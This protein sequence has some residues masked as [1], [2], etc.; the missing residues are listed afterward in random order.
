MIVDKNPVL[1]EV[2]GR[3]VD[4]YDKSWPC[5]KNHEWRRWIKDTSSEKFK[6][7]KIKHDISFEQAVRRRLEKLNKKPP[8]IYT[9]RIPPNRKKI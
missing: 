3:S 7:Y 5:K 6:K 2:C 8:E 4:E 9:N 1:C